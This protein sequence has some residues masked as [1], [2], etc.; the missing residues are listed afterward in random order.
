MDNIAL[1]ELI[2][3]I[4]LNGD[5]DFF[6]EGLKVLTQT[7][8]EAEVYSP[9]RNLTTWSRHSMTVHCEAYHYLRQSTR[10]CWENDE[11]GII[12]VLRWWDMGVV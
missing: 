6:R 2:R 8:V 12:I 4:Q 3:K 11:S 1:L 9:V 7:I 10:G 5:V